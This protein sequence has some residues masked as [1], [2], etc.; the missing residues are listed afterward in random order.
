MEPAENKHRKFTFKKT[1]LWTVAGILL[2]LSGAGIYFYKN[3][4]RLLSDALLKSFNANI[5]SDVYELKFKDLNVNLVLGNIKV[6][7]VVLQPR[8]KPLNNYPYINSKIRL[9]TKELLLSNVEIMTLLKENRLQLER[10]KIDEPDVEL[11]IDNK[12]PIFLPFNDSTLVT[13]TLQQTVK[14]PITAFSLEKF[15]LIDATLHLENFAKERDL[16]VKNLNITLR[17]LLLDQQYGKDLMKYSAFS[18]SIDE[19]TG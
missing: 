10:I 3:F 17:D 2:V 13:D 19:I 5:A 7:D 4:N 11:T 8:E 1:L 12:I 16:T 18:F 14:R 6:N 15:D 9:T